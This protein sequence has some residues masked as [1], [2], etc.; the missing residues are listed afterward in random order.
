VSTGFAGVGNL[1]QLDKIVEKAVRKL[2]KDKDVVSVNFNFDEDSTGDPSIYFRIVL[3]DAATRRDK[4]LATTE[5]IRAI[6]SKEI[7]PHDW[8]FHLYPGFRSESEQKELKDP[9]WD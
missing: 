9:T 5:R 3:I 7:Q 4:L 1:A 2:R 8:G 6:L